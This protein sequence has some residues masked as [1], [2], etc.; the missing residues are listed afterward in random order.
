MIT[1]LR[2]CAEEHAGQIMDAQ[3]AYDAR[4]SN[5]REFTAETAVHDAA[6]SCSRLSKTPQRT[7]RSVKIDAVTSNDSAEPGVRILGNSLSSAPTVVVLIDI[8]VSVPLAH[9]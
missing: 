3:G 5:W 4:S 6:G 8:D 1:A 9:L 7:E 2:R